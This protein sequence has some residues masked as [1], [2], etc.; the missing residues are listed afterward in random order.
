MNLTEEITKAKADEAAKANA[1]LAEIATAALEKNPWTAAHFN[2][3]RQMQ[4]GERLPTLA[5]VLADRAAAGTPLD[6]DERAAW[7]SAIRQEVMNGH[8]A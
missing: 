5:K 3:T 8:A 2:L 4:I 6:A 1:T 7:Q